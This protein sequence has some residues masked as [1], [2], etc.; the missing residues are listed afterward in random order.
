VSQADIKKARHEVGLCLKIAFSFFPPE[1]TK[2]V[3]RFLFCH[4]FEDA[5]AKP[6]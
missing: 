6:N 3:W 5:P 4:L 1:K 2:L